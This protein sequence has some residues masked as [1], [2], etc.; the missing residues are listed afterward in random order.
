M[1]PNF[2]GALLPTLPLP[3]PSTSR[4]RRVQLRYRR[5]FATVTL[6]NNCIQSINQLASSSASTSSA[7]SHTSLN[8]RTRTRLLDNIRSAASRFVSRQDSSSCDDTSS[9]PPAFLPHDHPTI[10]YTTSSHYAVPIVAD[11]VSLP[12]QA[13]TASLLDVLPPH[14]STFYSEPRNVLRNVPAVC[15][16]R[17]VPFVESPAEYLSL[18]RRM[19]SLGMLCYRSSVAV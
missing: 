4:S 18:V 13:G 7:L 10:D 14:L 12:H 8:P 9:S 17:P 1:K 2:P 19:H 15:R 5:S 6:A 3:P 11:R 16:A